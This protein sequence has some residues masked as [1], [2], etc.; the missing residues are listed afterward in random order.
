[1]ADHKVVFETLEDLKKKRKGQ[2]HENIVS[3]IKSNH[4]WADDLINKVLLDMISKELIRTV[5]VN[6]KTSYRSVKN[7]MAFFTESSTTNVSTVTT[8]DYKES[9]E[10]LEQDFIDFKMFVTKELSELKEHSFSNKSTETSEITLLREHIKCLEQQWNEKQLIID[11]LIMN[12]NQAPCSPMNISE[13]TTGNGEAKSPQNTPNVSLKIKAKPK[14]AKKKVF[15]V[16]DSLLNGINEKGFK[17]QNVYIKA[18]SGATSSDITHYIKPIIH[19]KPDIIIVHCGTNDIPK[20]IKTVD[21]LKMMDDYIKSNSPDTKLVISSLIARKDKPSYQKQVVTM[22]ERLK[23]FTG[24]NNI[25]FIENTNINDSCL[26][27]SKLHLNKKGNSCFANN[28]I[29]YLKD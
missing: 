17:D 6:Q 4:G 20:D 9:F 7:D 8:S 2:Y 19:K 21:N 28:L 3:H 5:T 1:M 10:A 14:K 22:N 27:R 11:G 25:D 13:K 29:N 23:K 26:S 18:H 12:M 24:K 16:G 15:V